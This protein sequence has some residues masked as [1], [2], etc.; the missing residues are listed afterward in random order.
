MGRDEKPRLPNRKRNSGRV[1]QTIRQEVLLIEA[2]RLLERYI[3]RG[4]RQKC[5]DLLC[6]L[7]ATGVFA[8]VAYVFFERRVQRIIRGGRGDDALSGCSLLRLGF[9]SLKMPIH[10]GLT[11]VLFVIFHL[12]LRN[13]AQHRERGT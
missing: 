10:E 4:R 1:V 12:Y 11:A 2:A 9:A 6:D 8:G 13:G 5:A 3:E 7:I